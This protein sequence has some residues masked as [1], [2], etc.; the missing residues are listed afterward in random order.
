MQQAVSAVLAEEIQQSESAGL[1][2][3]MRIFDS[4]PMANVGEY[5]A[6]I[7]RRQNCSPCCAVVAL[8][9]IERLKEKIPQACV[10]SHNIRLL[11]LTAMMIATKFVEDE[12]YTNRDWAAITG[13]P[14]CDLNRLELFMLATLEWR[15]AVSHAEFF[16]KRKHVLKR[17]HAAA[18]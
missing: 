16:A 9:Y 5:L 12:V 14:L 3:S 7:T 2:D 4:P 1:R 18:C 8:V 6:M 17:K 15:M 13:T 11:L 10:N